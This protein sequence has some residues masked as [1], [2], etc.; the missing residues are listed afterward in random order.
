MNRWNGK[1]V[2]EIENGLD[3]ERGVFAACRRKTI[4]FGAAGRKQRYFWPVAKASF[5]DGK[6]EL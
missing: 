6:A 4:A 2:F 1:A 5:G 3:S